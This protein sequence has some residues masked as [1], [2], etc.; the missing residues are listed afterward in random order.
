MLHNPS[1]APSCRS[2]R[3]F[4]QPISVKDN[5]EFAS[6]RVSKRPD[7]SFA[8]ER[9]R[10]RSNRFE[11]FRRST[12]PSLRCRRYCCS[13]SQCSSR[14]LRAR[15]EIA[16]RV[17]LK[18]SPSGVGPRD[19]L[20]GKFSDGISND[21]PFVTEIGFEFISICAGLSPSAV[22]DSNIFPAFVVER[23]TTRFTPF[24]TGSDL[25][26]Y[27]VIRTLC[28]TTSPFGFACK[29]EIDQIQC[30]WTAVSVFVD[31][32][33]IDQCDVRTV[34]TESHLAK[35]AASNGS[36]KDRRQFSLHPP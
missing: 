27:I 31:D 6:R 5:S 9:T 11:N 2:K 28:D 13:L 8:A 22:A 1:F 20:S 21:K 32:L 35:R 23:N 29:I 15:A 19:R 34:G 33:D 7:R 10:K 25:F 36:Q 26:R 12:N 17:C 16:N 18:D 30:G 14:R 4:R 3:L 24:S